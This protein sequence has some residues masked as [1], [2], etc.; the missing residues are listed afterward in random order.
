MRWVWTLPATR[1]CERLVGRE[2]VMV[3]SIEKVM[4]FSDPNGVAE[5]SPGLA[6][7]LDYPGTHNERR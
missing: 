2:V 5:Y 1:G 7:L 4:P 3:G 6:S